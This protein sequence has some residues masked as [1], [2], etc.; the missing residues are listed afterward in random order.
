[1]L[2][3]MGLEQYAY[4]L[5][6][7]PDLFW[8]LYDALLERERRK[9]PIV[10]E[11]P[12]LMVQSC[13][14]HIASFL[15]RKLFVDKILPSL[16]ESAE[17]LHAAGKIQSVHV[18]GDNAIWADDLAQSP[19]DVIEAFTPAPD[20][21]MTMAE[22]RTAFQDKVMWINFPS[23]LHLSSAETIRTAAREILECLQPGDRF[24]L[25]ITE[26]VPAWSWR[27]SL[28]AIQDA[29]DLYGTY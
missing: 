6:D 2:H 1:M 17:I 14:N 9:Y 23:S 8:T 5:A 15:G 24:I 27:T 13:A 22:A 12:V 11:A 21:D 18:D 29:I 7:H 26:D 20:T 25:G 3:Y 19:V 4:E 16:A 10:A 28:N